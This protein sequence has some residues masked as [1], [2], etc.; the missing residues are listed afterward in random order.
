ML[1]SP[2]ISCLATQKRASRAEPV[3]RMRID[4]GSTAPN[5]NG[6]NISKAMGPYRS[7]RSTCS[8]IEWRL[9][10]DFFL[11]VR[12]FIED[13]ARKHYTTTTVFWRCEN[14]QSKASRGSDC[15]LEACEYVT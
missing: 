1:I 4:Q 9:I 8:S 2:D 12:K 14:H 15:P 13:T 11:D 7:I 6:P 10:P 5:P 3:S